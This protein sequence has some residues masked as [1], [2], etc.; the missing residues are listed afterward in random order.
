MTR[1]VVLVVLALVALLALRIAVERLRSKGVDR[2]D[3]P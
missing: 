1:V 2:R 3:T